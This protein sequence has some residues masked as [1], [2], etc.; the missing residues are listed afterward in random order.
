MVGRVRMVDLA[1][2]DL[3]PL[4]TTQRG[5]RAISEKCSVGANAFEVEPPTIGPPDPYRS[6]SAGK[7]RR[8]PC[9][10]GYSFGAASP[11]RTTPEPSIRQRRWDRLEGFGDGEDS[12]HPAGY[13]NGKGPVQRREQ[14]GRPPGRRHR[15]TGRTPPKPVLAHHMEID[16]NPP[17][18]EPYNNPT[19][20]LKGDIVLTVAFHRLRPADVKGGVR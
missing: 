14:R 19:A 5:V 1:D 8:P 20:W 6:P 13:R 3:E 16:F 4:R 2:L 10:S 18:P 11:L 9:W 7:A 15:N 17:L 12:D